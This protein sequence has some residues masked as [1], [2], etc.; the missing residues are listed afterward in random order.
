MSSATTSIGARKTV[1]IRTS[2]ALSLVVALFLMACSPIEQQGE[3]EPVRVGLDRVARGEVALPG[4]ARFGLIV[5]S[6]SVAADGRHAIDVLQAAGV[7]VVRLFG[8]E[9]GL[10]GQAAAGERVADGRDPISGLPVVSLYG[11][12]KKPRAED[13]AD[14]DGLIFDLQCAGVRFY[15][16]VST[17]ILSLQAA[18]ESDIEFI[19][20]DRPNPLGGDRIEGPVAAPRSVV[21]MSFVNM[22]P[23]PLV[24]GLTLG[25]MARYVNSRLDQ[26]ARLR[27][28]EMVGWQRSMTWK[29]TGRDWVPPSPNLRSAEAA[30][31][32]PGV[33]LLETTNV[34]EGRGT[35][36]PFLLFGAPWL[37]PTALDLD[38]LARAVPGI[39]LTPTQFEPAA[40]PAAPHPK[41]VD[42]ICRGLRID[43]T[44]ESAL[45][46]YRLGL[47]LVRRLARQDAFAWRQDGRA[48][49]WLLGTPV[50]FEALAAN[51]SV[52]EIVGA[53]A[54]DHERWRSE[55]AS[56]LLY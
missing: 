30:L 44:D 56:A 35:E 16:Y 21:P 2:L 36:A 11:E 46:G 27:V 34:S 25:E 39:R 43:V 31:A 24:H 55:R 52:S 29:D 20:L 6:A 17:L 22:A 8:P 48:L 28:V 37:D 51:R 49:T 7:E 1:E 5:H 19:V 15:T 4:N 38:D 3:R 12:F 23:G 53:D 41:Y 33:A 10:R 9:H 47:E 54:P 45:E 40:G 50:V 26:P 42:E 18:A 14:L 13:L 32:Y